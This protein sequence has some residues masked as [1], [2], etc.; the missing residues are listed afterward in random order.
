[1]VLL[2]A[3]PALCQ[4][5][6]SIDV[7]RE[8][9]DVVNLYT[10]AQCLSNETTTIPHQVL[11]DVSRWTKQHKQEADVVSLA[12]LLRLTNIHAPPLPHR[13]KS[14][15]LQAILAQIKLEQEQKQYES[16]TSLQYSPFQS[17]IP[18]RDAY[19]R[20]NSQTSRDDERDKNEWKQIKR[21]VGAIVN[22]IVSM[23]TVATGVW[24]VGGGRKVEARLALAMFGAVAIAAIEGFLYYRFF[25]TYSSSVKLRRQQATQRQ[26]RLTTNNDKLVIAAEGRQTRS[27]KHKL[28]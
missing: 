4:R 25:T 19:S 8:L 11:V 6:S 14:P 3:T 17:T 18:T 23:M 22:V 2:Q 26:A 24:W 10:T 15:R 12:S 27:M 5:L 21:Q 9:A 1:M 13:E 28:A 20:L 16:M 7:P